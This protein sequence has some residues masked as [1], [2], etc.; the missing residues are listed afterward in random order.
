MFAQ[1]LP[2]FAA[3]WRLRSLLAFMDPVRLKLDSVRLQLVTTNNPHGTLDW[4][5]AWNQQTSANEDS[6]L[7]PN[8]WETTVAIA[9]AKVEFGGGFLTNGK[10]QT[11]PPAVSQHGIWGEN[12]GLGF[13]NKWGNRLESQL[14]RE[15]DAKRAGPTTTRNLP[16]GSE[17]NRKTEPK[18]GFEVPY[19]FFPLSLKTIRISLWVLPQPPHLLKTPIQLRMFGDLIYFIQPLITVSLPASKEKG[20]PRSCTKRQAFLGRRRVGQR[21]EEAGLFQV[22]C[23]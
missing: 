1:D 13:L 22:T 8:K 17:M 5:K 20:A 12:Q 3:F 7:L 2:I 10:L 15:L 21:N 14:D 18:K 23:P 4:G 19:L 9:V 16:W 11:K 6:R